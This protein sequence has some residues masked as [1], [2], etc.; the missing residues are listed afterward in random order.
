M[1]SIIF[2]DFFGLE[3]TQ[4]GYIMSFS[5]FLQMVSESGRRGPVRGCGLLG[6]RTSVSRECPCPAA[7]SACPGQRP[8]VG[9]SCCLDEPRR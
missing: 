7:L 8:L 9:S 4:A 2:M 3:P 5:G 6:V 1:F